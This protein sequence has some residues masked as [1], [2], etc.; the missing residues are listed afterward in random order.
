MINLRSLINIGF[1]RINL[2]G[3]IF[4]IAILVMLLITQRYFKK[5]N[6]DTSLAVS[7]TFYSILS[8]I[9]GARLFYMLFYASS[10][11]IQNP[12]E[13]FYF[14]QG[15]LSFHGG[16]F[17]MLI[18][19]YCF[20]KKHNLDFLEISDILVIPTSLILAIGRIVNFLDNEIY[21][22]ITNLP[23][24]IHFSAIEECRHPIQLYDSLNLLI[25]FIIL[26]FI[27][28][29]KRKK[30]TILLIFITLYSLLRFFLDFMR[31]YTTYYLGIGTGQYLSL[32]TLIIASYMFARLIIKETTTPLITNPKT[33]T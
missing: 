3:I 17:G 4:A 27:N 5:K 1:A 6:K 23:W 32:L 7:I 28:R 8:A 22:K 16:L 13:I 30:G 21:G 18:G 20:C 14:W 25:I 9:I 26:L 31:Q 24:C 12:F 10:S 15:G 19:G 29:K 2:Y 11:F 33:S